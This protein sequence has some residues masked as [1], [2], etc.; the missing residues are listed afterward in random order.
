MSMRHSANSSK[1]QEFDPESGDVTRKRSLVKPERSRID[2]SHPRYHYTQVANQESS[3]LKIL[4]SSTGLAP[5]TSQA[6]KLT[7]HNEAMEDGED[8]SI[9]LMDMHKASSP[10]GSNS[11]GGREVFGLNDEFDYSPNKNNVIKSTSKPTQRGST[12]AGGKILP[13]K[14]ASDKDSEREDVDFWKVYCYI[15]TFWAPAPLLKLFG[16]KTKEQQYAWREK[17]A[18]ISCIFMM[19]AI[20]AYIIFGFT[21]T[22][23][24][25]QRPRT[26]INEVQTNNLIINGRA[27]DLGASQHPKAAGI[28]AGANVLYP[29]INAG[30]MDASFLFQN[31]NGNCKGL[32]KARDN[33]TIPH[34]DNFEDLAW[35]MP[36]HLMNQDGSTKA[37][38]S[39][40]YYNGWACHTSTVARDAYYGLKVNGDVYFTWDDIRN[41]SRNLVVYSGDVLDLDLINWFQTD[42]LTY[43]ELF[44]QIRDDMAFRG[45]DI[46]LALTNSEQRRAARCLTEIIKVGTIDSETIGCIASSVVL[47]VS[48][49]FILAVVVAKF[50]MACYFRWYISAKQGANI[51]DNK[52]SYARNKEIENWVDDPSS[53]APINTVPEEQRAN[54]H[55]AK[56]NRQSVFI[57]GG[58]TRLANQDHSLNTP[59]GIKYTTMTTQ[60]A[61]LKKGHSKSAS[62][63]LYRSSTQ[64]LLSPSRPNSVYNPFDDF[65]VSGLSQDIIHPDVVPQPPANYMPFGYPLAHTMIIVTAYSEDEE[66]LRTTMDSLC[67][68]DYPNSH[69]LIVVV[70]DGL[71]KGSGNDLTTPEIA[72]SMMTDFTIAPEDVKPCSYVA[73]AQGSKRHNMAKLYSGFYKYTDS[74]PLEKQQRVPVLTV[75]KCGTPEEAN[76]AKPGNRGKRDS[77]ILLM[78]FLQKVMFDERMTE[79]EF[80]MLN[81]IWRVTGIMAEFYEIL[82]MVDA[83]T[84]VYPDCLTHMVAEMVKDPMVMGLCGETKISNKSQ[85]W[86]TAIQVFEYYISHHLAK[87]FESVFGGVTCLP[88]CFCMYRIKAPKGN[89]GYW[90]PIL[91]NPDIVERYSDNVVDTLHRKNLLLLGED[92]YLSSLMLRTFPKRKQIFIPKAACKTIVPDTFKVLLSQRRRWIN[93]TVHNLMELV[94][95]K[96][97]CGTF[98]FSMQFVIAI[99]LVG[100]LILPVALVFTIYVVVFAIVSHPTPIMSLVLLAIIFGLPGMMIVITVSSWS[101]VVYF[102]IYILALPIWNFVLPSYSYWKFDDFSWGETRLVSGGDKGNHGEVEGKFD[103]S[104]IQMKRWREFER[105]RRSR[106]GLSVPRATWDPAM[107]KDEE[108]Y[109]EVSP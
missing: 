20:V 6:S 8:A 21:R 75:V 24:G 81:S 60:A 35:Y 26:R 89:D 58:A 39:K 97:L 105:E 90:V 61:S 54:Y 30:G 59:G 91:A 56:T 1:Y 103:S 29:P 83:D 100:T 80:E 63:T 11:G 85:T 109:S 101:Y 49:I 40:P 106:E 27:Y 45:H 33:S 9:P 31:V 74:V 38:F 16:I 4:P 51:L 67:T 78:S 93:S 88:G 2:P 64:D 32:I 66:G 47:Y 102:F 18:L 22:V 108:D 72:L 68:T 17:I 46:S 41:S 23:C 70:C 52:S 3:H 53:R 37:N 71:I 36:C 69:K 92:R 14:I 82:L 87:A 28:T 79:F 43:P 86:V 73:V 96:D 7:A 77:Q 10:T 57:K 76:A 13:N 104:S 62:R 15:V 65:T 107:E 84:K 5:Q 94:L 55:T 95:V 12:N 19:G 98:C 48:L 99:E 42:D 25:E 34:S 50:L 44:N